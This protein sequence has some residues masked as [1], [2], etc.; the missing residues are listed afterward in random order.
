MK[1][2]S[3]S[4]DRIMIQRYCKITLYLNERNVI[5]K[6]EGGPIIHKLNLCLTILAKISFNI[7]CLYLKLHFRTVLTTFD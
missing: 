3:E 1:E 4:Y 6:I 5:C 2:I 7:C